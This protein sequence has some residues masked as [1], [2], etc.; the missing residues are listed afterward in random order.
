M[1]EKVPLVVP[2]DEFNRQ[3]VANTHPSDW[4]NPTAGGRY[5]M[6]VIGA[7]TAG[8]VTAIIAAGLGGKVALI[9]RHL[10]GGDCLNYGCVPSKGLIRA[11]R[12]AADA[13][14]SGEFGVAG[15]EKLAVDFAA[16]ME[17]MRRLRASISR[18]DAAS[19]FQGEGVD[20]YLGSGRFAGRDTIEVAGQTLRFHR[21][22]IATGARAAAPPI[23]GLEET[24]YLTNETIFSLTE[25]PSRLG[26]IGGGPIGCEMGQS[27]AR[28]GSSVTQLEM[29][30]HVLGRDDADAALRVQKAM[31]A[32][33]VRIETG[34]KVVSTTSGTTGKIIRFERDGRLEEVVVDEILVAVGRAP[35]VE[36]L[37]L[38]AAGVEYGRRGVKVDD[39]LRTANPR[40]YAAGDICFAY[41]FTH[42]ADALAGIVIRNALFFGRRKASSLT[43]PWCTYT[44]PE[45]AHVGLSPEQALE[46]GIE[47]DT[48]EVSF[49]DVDRAVLDGDEEG[50]AKIHVKRGTAEI[51]GA[52]LLARHAGEM[53]SEITLA[54]THGLGLDKIAQTIHPYPTQSEVWKR[55][56]NAYMKT[57][58]TP[59]AK[60]WTTRLLAWRR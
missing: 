56:A 46:R 50:L 54:I 40:V 29:G 19:R 22:C 21:A 60:R 44:D 45:L 14:D 52:T 12:A 11:A 25:L 20:V 16:V 3:L 2:D 15:C 13:R 18:H 27:F 1:S 55:L 23:E 42:T 34:V 32:D 24:G 59:G 49:A 43:I 48:F 26:V 30:P 28:F 36:G 57:K 58:L 9:E 17:R 35:N 31:L 33:G 38:E 8:L 37:G 7:G 51:V 4:V 6:V 39:H 10:L 47:T 5:N 53:I 41:K